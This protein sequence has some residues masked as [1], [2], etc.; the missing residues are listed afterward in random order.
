MKLTP[1]EVIF[2]TG[3][4]IGVLRNEE[5][6]NNDISK[7]GTENSN[8]KN[9]RYF[10]TTPYLPQSAAAELIKP[11]GTGLKKQL[12]GFRSECSVAGLAKTGACRWERH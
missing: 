12:V 9:L 2:K 6:E 3:L 11:L 5:V 10:A 7:K 4:L 1:H 8:S